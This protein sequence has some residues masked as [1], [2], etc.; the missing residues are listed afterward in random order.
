MHVEYLVGRCPTD[1]GTL[2]L[3]ILTPSSERAK[4]FGYRLAA[5][6]LPAFA[7]FCLHQSAKRVRLSIYEPHYA[8]MR[9]SRVSCC[10]AAFVSM[11]TVSYLKVVATANIVSSTQWAY[12]H[13]LPIAW[14]YRLPW[15]QLHLLPPT[16]RKLASLALYLTH[17]KHHDKPRLRTLAVQVRKVG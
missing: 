2:H 17:K 15:L 16:L 12:S 8:T 3:C 4:S 10:Y 5:R 14:T 13:Q 11:L 7:C 1:L 6:S 9:N